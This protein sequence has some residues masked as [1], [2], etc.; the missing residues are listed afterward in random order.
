MW[1]A[2]G[3]YTLSCLVDKCSWPKHFMGF[4]QIGLHM[5]FVQFLGQVS[6][7]KYFNLKYWNVLDVKYFPQ[8]LASGK[9]YISGIPSTTFEQ[10]F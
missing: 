6:S 2:Q 8:I 10:T 5:Y 9:Y 7:A 3:C 1:G 4:S